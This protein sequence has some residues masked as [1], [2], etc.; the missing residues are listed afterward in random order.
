MIIRL[1][2]LSTVL[3]S[4]GDK[5]Q[6]NEQTQAVIPIVGTWR[7]LSGTT[8][9]K[10]DTTVTDYTKDLSFIKIINDTHFA[11]LK[12]DLTKGKGPSAAY[13]SGGGS[14]TLTDSLYTEHL[15]YCTEREWEGNT[16]QFTL[17]LKN[18]TLIQQ[19]VEKVADAGIDRLNIERYVRLKK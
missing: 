19:G 15:D 17:T 13:N 18:D 1:L 16:F 7:L 10:G 11:F 6:T 14:Y 2:L 9:E 12:H 3:L 5:T 8:I 4:C